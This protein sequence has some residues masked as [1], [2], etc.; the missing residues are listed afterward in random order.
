M[1]NAILFAAVASVFAIAAV[2][3]AQDITLTSTATGGYPI[4][5][6]ID[7]ATNQT[8]EILSASQGASLDFLSPVIP[9]ATFGIK[10]ANQIFNQLPAPVVIAGP[11]TIRFCKGTG[12]TTS[13]YATFRICPQAFPAEKTEIIPNLSN[14]ATVTFQTSTNL[15]DWVATTNGIYSGTNGALFFRI[16]MD[17]AE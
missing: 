14:G 2:L 6:T 17:R 5:Q 12:G 1:K 15:V 16:K 7:I 3:P 11:A 4:Y 8:L 9:Q 13:E 10:S